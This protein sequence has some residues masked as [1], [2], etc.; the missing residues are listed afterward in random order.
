M[1]YAVQQFSSSGNV[2]LKGF[3]ELVTLSTAKGLR[4]KAA[5]F[6]T[7]RGRSE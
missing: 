2:Q 5:R 7:P 1:Q 3:T 6:F 4:R